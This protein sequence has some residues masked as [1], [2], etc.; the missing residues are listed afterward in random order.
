MK[1]KVAFI[2]EH[3]SPLAMLG[4][5]DSGGQN[6]YVGE[7]AKHLISL[8]YEIDIFTRSDNDDMPAIIEWIPGV[9]VIHIKAGPSEVIA[10]ENIFPF[11]QEF[12]TK[13]L[14]FIKETKIA[15]AL[16]HANFWMSGKVAIEIKKTLAVPFVITF[17]ALGVIRKMHQG[18][19]DKFPPE[20]IDV[21]RSIVEEADH[22]I[23]ECPQDKIDLIEYYDAVPDKITIIPCG[24]NPAEFY[25]MDKHLARMVLGFDTNEC[26]ILQL[27][28]IV[29][30]K[31]IDNVIRSLAH[32]DASIHFR[33]V[34]VGGEHD[35]NDDQNPEIIRLRAI[36]E[37]AGVV[38]RVTFAG[39]KKRDVLKYYYAAAD[40]FVTTP[41]YEPFGI[42]PL[43]SMA[44]GT[45]VIGSDVGGIKYSIEDG[46]TGFLVPPNEAQKLAAKIS[47]LLTNP[48]LLKK[49]RDTAV[50]RANTMF[51]WTKIAELMANLYERVLLTA[52][53]HSNEEVKRLNFIHN[54][55]EHA[56]HTL[57]KSSE[58]LSVL[59]CR[60]ATMMAGCFRKN[61]KV[62]ICGNGGSAAESQ[63]LA[64][65]L[66]GRFGLPERQALPAIALTTDG[67][68]ATAWANDVGFEDVFARQVEAY[69]QKGDI[70][71]CFSTSG[72]SAN[73]IQAM[74][75]ALE[76]NMYCIALTGKGG[77]E[78]SLY[79]HI[80]LIAPSSNTQR[81]QETHLHVLHT[82]CSLIEAD[83]FK[84]T[85]SMPVRTNGQH[86][87]IS[88][89]KAIVKQEHS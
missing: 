49:M 80:N 86:N 61:K 42:T 88:N 57:M 70:L 62:L 31:G 60:A 84:A 87:G 23:A 20:R 72:Q 12:A 38:E 15:Y 37:Q 35:D 45:P 64:A 17:H 34:I 18:D 8:G 82:I 1:R 68:V 36:A 47:L 69:G 5:V 79:A 33:L 28:R 6:V 22:I 41:W 21:E 54:A 76:K 56:A 19:D 59:I 30:R 75:K 58:N 53:A 16:V 29:P 46:V 9:R 44:C 67:A 71:F 25:P 24:F 27:G 43:E 13:V 78:M 66:V 40:I 73:V 77:G 2:S 63:H 10:K 83:L 39:R 85:L 52:P 65:E 50:R 51:T 48:S 4:G 74:R 26:L 11:M 81:I 89:G 32:I 55:F 14:S 3:A 7:L